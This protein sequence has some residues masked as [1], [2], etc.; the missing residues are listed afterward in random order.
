MIAALEFL[1]LLGMP[2]KALSTTVCL[3]PSPAKKTDDCNAGNHN[4]DGIT[5]ENTIRCVRLAKPNTTI[6]DGEEDGDASKIAVD[7]T[8][9]G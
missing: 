6:D 7:N 5:N 2:N 9:H 8:K 4:S 1:R 3:E